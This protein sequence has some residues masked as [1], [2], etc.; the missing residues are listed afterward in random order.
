MTLVTDVYRA[1]QK[2]PKE[3][4]YGI[5]KQMRRAAVSVP[6]NIAQGQGRRFEGEF[7]HFLRTARGSLLELETQILTSRNLGY[8]DEAGSEQLIK[9]SEE[10]GRILNGLLSAIAPE[11]AKAAKSVGS[12]GN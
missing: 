3:E 7:Q 9:S 12:T 4:L 5:V 11:K 2:F 10:V 8:L 1:T 6:S